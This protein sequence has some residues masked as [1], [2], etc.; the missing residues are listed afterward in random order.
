MHDSGQLLKAPS[1]Y[2]SNDV[3]INNNIII[4]I[5]TTIKIITVPNDVTLFGMVTDESEVQASK[6]QSPYERH[7]IIIIIIIN[8]NNTN[9]LNTIRNSN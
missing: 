6:A 8:N 9:K 3:V 4:I 5:K 1:P 7:I 2:E